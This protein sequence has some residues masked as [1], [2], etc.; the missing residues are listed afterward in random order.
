MNQLSRNQALAAGFSA[1]LL[2]G[3]FPPYFALLLPSTPLEILSHRIFWSFV[4]VLAVLLVLRGGWAW[5][6]E[7]VFTKAT[8]PKLLLAAVLIAANWLTYIWAVNN[9]HVVE[10]SMGYFIN[11]LVS[12]ILGVLIFR[13]RLGLGGRIGGTVALLGVVV[14][15]WGHWTT[16]W[17]SLALA[18][19]FGFYGAV[20][21]S[22]HLS[23]LQGLLVESGLLFP[24]AAGYLGVLAAQGTGRFG[25][26]PGLTL[27]LAASGIVTA[28]PLWLF[29]VAA[30]RLSLGVLGVLQYVAP[31][32]QFLFGILL[33]AE[34]VSLSYWI[35]LILIWIGSAVYLTLTLRSSA[36]PADVPEPAQ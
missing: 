14:I 17:I 1:Y 21:K 5:V 15:S 4:S 25:T 3:L 7:G 10:A 27:L 23:G 33:F 16:L 12:V 34:P 30:P 18:F 9:G 8:F 28:L 31:T 6:R 22:A 19:S 24:L 35:G 26:T 20:K 11:P 29:A 13:E 36:G 2:W 32:M